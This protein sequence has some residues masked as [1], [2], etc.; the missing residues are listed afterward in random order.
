MLIFNG[1]A[2]LMEWL[3]PWELTKHIVLNS[4]K[5]Y[6]RESITFGGVLTY[7]LG[8]HVDYRQGARRH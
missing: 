1:V 5:I 3:W 8:K 2:R 6:F 7:L 4:S